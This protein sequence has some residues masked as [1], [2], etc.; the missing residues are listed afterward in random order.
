MGE[1]SGAQL[2]LSEM[3]QPPARY[4]AVAFLAFSVSLGTAAALGVA[5]FVTSFGLN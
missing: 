2:Y 5:S 4:P 1:I 3:I